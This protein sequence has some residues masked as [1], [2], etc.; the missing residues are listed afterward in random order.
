MDH[1]RLYNFT[2]YNKWSNILTIL[3]R[4]MEFLLSITN[5]ENIHPNLKH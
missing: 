1:K 2:I 3:K 4:N 5:L